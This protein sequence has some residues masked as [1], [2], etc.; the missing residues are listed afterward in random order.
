MSGRV[1]LICVDF[2]PTRKRVHK[3]YWDEAR[4]QRNFLEN[5]AFKLNI[6]SPENLG[7]L[8]V[9]LITENG[10]A[11]LLSKF[12]GSVQ[13]VLREAYPNLSLSCHRDTAP[14]G[15][16]T[17]HCNRQVFLEQFAKSLEFTR[18]EQWYGVRIVDV[19]QHKG[20]RG[21]LERYN[22]SMQKALE[23][24][25]PS[26][27]W[28]PW[29]FRR[30]RHG[31]WTD[32]RNL[33]YFTEWLESSLDIW[34]PA[35]WY[36]VCCGRIIRECKGASTAL[37]RGGG[38]SGL[39]SR[40]FPLYQWD[41][42]QTGPPG[43]LRKDQQ[44]L[45]ARIRAL[46]ED[47]AMMRY[48]RKDFS[49]ESID[50]EYRAFCEDQKQSVELDIYIREHS[51]AFEYQGVQHYQW[52]PRFGSPEKQI[53]R[54]HAKSLWCAANGITLLE[55]A[56]WRSTDIDYLAETIHKSRPD[57]LLYYRFVEANDLLAESRHLSCPGMI[58]QPLLSF[59]ASSSF[60]A[61]D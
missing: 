36:S 13:R 56:H 59:C 42:I 3:G 18:S 60:D 12:G 26:Q 17:R 10:G 14:R 45:S 49:I 33:M 5:L 47:R 21:F 25:F 41:M 29:L 28:M 55:I 1:R 24:L 39:L 38:L 57:L 51:L 15:H 9:R 16:W 22:G 37:K 2:F 27:K 32:E 11:G 61:C 52:N 23:D 8:T 53:Q 19:L 54:D 48:S 4:N 31:F 40:T 44:Q 46:M 34:H 30:A 50:V 7:S 20:G 58:L 35:Q 6:K 43:P